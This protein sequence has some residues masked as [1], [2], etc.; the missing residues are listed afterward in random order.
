VN[1]LT[2]ELAD[3]LE[4]AT[5]PTNGRGYDADFRHFAGWAARTRRATAAQG[6]TPPPATSWPAA[7]PRA[8]A[9]PAAPGPR[10]KPRWSPPSSR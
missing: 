4:A 10:P 9:A 3:L 1:A 5:A 2:D 6:A 8:C 7:P